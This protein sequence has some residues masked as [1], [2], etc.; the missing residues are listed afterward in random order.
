MTTIASAIH[1]RKAIFEPS[2]D[3]KTIIETTDVEKVTM[4][5]EDGPFTV[6]NMCVIR[7]MRLK[8]VISLRMDWRG[9]VLRRW[10]HGP[11][12]APGKRRGDDSI[13]NYSDFVFSELYINSLNRAYCNNPL[14]L[15]VCA[16][17][18]IFQTRS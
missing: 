8:S 18:R 9:R 10:F 1:F 5:S 16:V 11:H 15:L 3:A 7:R 4:D 17:F 12:L 6:S 13:S 2:R 14:S